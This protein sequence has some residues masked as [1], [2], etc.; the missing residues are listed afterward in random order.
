M[1]L[2]SKLA[3]AQASQ[4]QGQAQAG[5]AP[6]PGAA[7]GGYAAPSGPPPGIAPGGGYA[8]PSGPPPG[9][10]QAGGYAYAQPKALPPVPGLAAPTAPR[11]PDIK[12]DVPTLT[13]VMK[14][15]VKEQKLDAF[16]KDKDLDAI[17]RRLVATNTIGNISQRLRVPLTLG[18]D[19]AKVALYDVVL[20]CDDSMSM[21]AH[22]GGARIE[23]LKSILAHITAACTLLDE[24]GIAVRF[25]NSNVEGNNI[26]AESQVGELVDRAKN[27]SG[28]PMGTSLDEKVLKPL[29][30]KPAKSLIK[31]LK[32]PLLIIVITD[33][34]PYGE[35]GV[36]NNRDKLPQVVRQT[37]AEMAKTK[38]GASA[39]AYQFAQVGDDEKAREFLSWLD[40]DPEIG[41]YID[42][43]MGFEYE[44]DQMAKQGAELS[45]EVWLMKLLLGAIDNSY[46][47]QDENPT[48]KPFRG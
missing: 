15:T 33:G 2:A 45:R 13:Q 11:Q 19:L 9:H 29:L 18:V 16:Y 5:Y 31:K 4:A 36:K 23:E 30:V 22:Q 10:H 6:P 42:Q 26:K 7:P 34:A 27:T 1:G 3:A 38:Y 43:T 12:A 32:K 8:S 40:E 47:I 44:Q 21:K 17:A 46:D 35:K 41:G 25:F 28:T 24:D 20:L 39:V 14:A 48:L 37:A